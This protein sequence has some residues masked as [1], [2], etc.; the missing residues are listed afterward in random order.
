MLKKYKWALFWALHT[1]ITLAIFSGYI[2]YNA[3]SENQHVFGLLSANQNP[4]PEISED[5]YL[6]L[7]QK[8]KNDVV[9]LDVRNSHFM[10]GNENERF[11]NSYF[12]INK[13]EDV[14]G[15]LLKN[16]ENLK[17]KDIVFLCYG[18]YEAR[19]YQKR[20]EEFLKKNNLNFNILAFEKGYML[21]DVPAWKVQRLH[22]LPNSLIDIWSKEGKLT[23]YNLN[24]ENWEKIKKDLGQ[25]PGDVLIKSPQNP[26]KIEQNIYPLKGSRY[27]P[28]NSWK[29]PPK[30]LAN[31]VYFFKGN[32][33]KEGLL[34]IFFIIFFITQ[35][36]L[37]HFRKKHVRSI[38]TGFF[39]LFVFYYPFCFLENF[40]H[41][42]EVHYPYVIQGVLFFAFLFRLSY[43]GNNRW[44][45][46]RAWVFWPLLFGVSI[47][48]V[49]ES[50]VPHHTFNK[51]S[52]F[53]F[54]ILCIYAPI[55][56][57]IFY[58]VRRKLDG[59][60]Q[61]TKIRRDRAIKVTKG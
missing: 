42:D 11:A 43:N 9:L 49:I 23:I 39:T 58:L 51:F 17:G 40:T 3:T 20:T 30:L 7:L 38:L 12:N 32:L 47:T 21:Q 16:K 45:F 35:G 33:S 13:Q 26:S 59:R 29:N 61:E 50:W 18:G 60:I 15:Y 14:N 28:D 55:L 2:F 56:D 8:K 57:F 31:A 46:K 5:D 36:I 1:L 34:I 41:P 53:S 22:F 6:D 4:Y 52:L 27:Y 19:V 37:A 10:P 48:M 25:Y 54:M 24:S 44:N